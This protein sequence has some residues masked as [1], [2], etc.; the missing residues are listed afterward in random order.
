MA[1]RIDDNHKSI[2]NGLRAV[3]AFVQSIAAVGRGCPDA[4]ISFRGTWYVAEIK[5][6]DKSPSRRRLTEAEADWH[7]K[8]EAPVYIW[9]NLE[10]ALRTIGASK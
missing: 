1:K 3:G 5:D 9:E 6:G 4:L 2:V 10:D 8:A 7:S